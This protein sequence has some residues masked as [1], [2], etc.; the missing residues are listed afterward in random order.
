MVSNKTEHSDE[1]WEFLQFVSGADQVQS[2]LDRTG[3]PTALRSLI[4]SQLEDID[5]S[6][7]ASQLPT[8]LT[9]YRGTDAAATEETFDEMIDQM[10]TSDE[11]DPVKIVELGATKVN[12]TIE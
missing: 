2:Y 1:A 9:W 7:F 8:A 12:Q 11:P 5:L 4:N 10:L 3:K 6:V